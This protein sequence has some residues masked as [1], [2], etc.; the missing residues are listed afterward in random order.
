VISATFARRFR[1]HAPTALAIAVVLAAYAWFAGGASFNF[2]RINWDQSY[3]ASLSE[4][5]F[6]GHLYMAYQPDPRLMALPFPYDYKAREGKVDYVWDA[7]YFNGHYYLYFSPLPALIFYMPYRLLRTGYPRDALAAAVFATWALLAAVGFV[8]RALALMGRRPRIPLPIWILMIGF[9]NVTLFHLMDIRVYEAAILA[10]SAMSATWAY[11]LVRYIESPSVSRAA[12]MGVWLALAISVRPNLLVLLTVTAY[13]LWDGFSTRARRVIAAAVPLA[14]V[15]AMLFGYNYA[16]FGQFLESGHTYQL[17]FVPMEGK[18]VCS[19]C[20]PAEGARFVNMALEYVF[21]APAVRS[22][23]PWV[24]LQF[25][26]PDPATSFPMGAEQILGIAPLV[27]LALVATLFAALLLMRRGATIDR[28]TRAGM[29][30]MLGSWLILFGLSTCWWIVSRYSLDFM[31]LM[32][33][34]TAVCIEAGL[35]W[36]DSL[37]MRMR[38]LRAAVIALACYTIILGFI[39]GLGGEEGPFKRLHPEKF[40]KIARLF[41]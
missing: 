37:G 24:N 41:R 26:N 25:A 8:R 14:I 23:F 5:F 36:L 39:I 33:A 35:E 28:G 21:W 20:T 34:A 15:A 16:R 13:V 18:R 7:S 19:L 31:Y 10:G 1:A 40:E 11:A 32:T 38:A 2:P 3:Y 22:K 29:L 4:G 12:W 6:H 9:G 27:P 17:T 30:L